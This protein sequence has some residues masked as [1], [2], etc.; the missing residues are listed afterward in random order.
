MR[1]VETDDSYTPDP[2]RRWQAAMER[3]EAMTSDDWER[4][5]YSDGE[6]EKMLAE[7]NLLTCEHPTESWDWTVERWLKHP[8]YEQTFWWSRRTA[9]AGDAEVGRGETDDYAGENPNLL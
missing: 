7:L 2:K 4:A 3:M 1:L 9:A 6:V 8:N 5:I